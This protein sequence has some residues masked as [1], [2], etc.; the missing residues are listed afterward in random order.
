MQFLSDVIEIGPQSTLATPQSSFTACLMVVGSDLDVA[1]ACTR[2]VPGVPL[3]RV[4]HAAGA[5]A[6]MLV[7]RPLVVVIDGTIRQSDVARIVESARGIGAEVVLAPKAD[8]ELITAIQ[9]AL[10]TTEQRRSRPASYWSQRP[11]VT[12]EKLTLPEG[13]FP[14]SI[15]SV[16]LLVTPSHL[17][18]YVLLEVE[19]GSGDLVVIRVGRSDTDLNLRIKKYL[20]DPKYEQDERY[21]LATHFSFAYLET[22]ES[23]FETECVLY[24][25]W[26]PQLNEQHPGQPR[27]S[28]VRCPVDQMDRCPALD[29][30]E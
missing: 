4:R 5:V 18:V 10:L 23:A 9:E 26:R 8:A 7:R 24:H 17:G 14:L 13:P 29:S 21:D 12:I 11:G 1:A 30:E 19:A 15:E 2:A 25:D 3:L 27:G 22:P 20:T 16:D 28:D 6:R